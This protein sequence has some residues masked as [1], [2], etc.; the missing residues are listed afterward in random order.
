MTMP[1][2]REAR[3]Q[4]EFRVLFDIMNSPEQAQTLATVQEIQRE[5]DALEALAEMVRE[6]EQPYVPTFFAS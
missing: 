2:S 4:P 3:T 6:I 5:S 1:E